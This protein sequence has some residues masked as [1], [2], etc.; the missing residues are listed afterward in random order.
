MSRPTEADL[1]LADDVGDEFL[2]DIF[3][4]DTSPENVADDAV[5][6]KDNV[7]DDD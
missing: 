2:V 7:D 6:D 4:R 1:T 3:R 5:D